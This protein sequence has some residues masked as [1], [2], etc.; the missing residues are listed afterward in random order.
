MEKSADSLTYIGESTALETNVKA[1]NHSEDTRP[2]STAS[3]FT[4]GGIV[5]VLIGI[6]RFS[7]H[8]RRHLRDDAGN[9]P[10]IVERL[11]VA[12]AADPT[13]SKVLPNQYLH[14]G[15]RSESFARHW[16]LDTTHSETPLHFRA[17]RLVSQARAMKEGLKADVHGHTERTK[18]HYLAHVLPAHT[19]HKHATEAQDAFHAEAVANFQHPNLDDENPAAAALAAAAYRSSS[20]AACWAAAADRGQVADVEIGL[21]SSGGNDPDEPTRP[22]SL[23]IN[24]CFTCPNGF[25]TVD[26]VP[27]L[28]AAVELTHLIEDHN[29]SEWESG[30]A[31]ELRLY[32]QAAL[33]QFPPLVVSN[34]RRDVDL[35]PHI[36]T[37]TGMYL[38]LKHG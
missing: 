29:A 38:E 15:W 1:R 17:L 10:P 4:P 25:R 16:P 22:C 37:V 32:A 21:C 33:D 19:F 13:Q 35:T 6:T 28:L 5:E 34:V 3:I 36:H 27:G 31:P 26:H 7:R 2:T 24:A 8:A 20:A 9:H 30:D 14:N 12:H 18:V 23:G 11:Y